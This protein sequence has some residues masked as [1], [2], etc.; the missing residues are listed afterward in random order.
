MPGDDCRTGFVSVA[1]GW[2]GCPVEDDWSKCPVMT[3]MICERNGFRGRTIR[4][5]G[6]VP[7]GVERPVRNGDG[8][9]TGT[10]GSNDA[11]VSGARARY[12][13]R[14]GGSKG[15]DGDRRGALVRGKCPWDDGMAK[16]GTVPRGENE[17]MLIPEM[18]RLSGGPS[19]RFPGWVPAVGTPETA[20]PGER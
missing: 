7:D 4:L 6:A 19:G 17:P 12:F 13:V 2:S 18:E 15:S 20:R 5:R 14:W 9:D 11:A 16:G 3:G 10:E 1:R 8:W